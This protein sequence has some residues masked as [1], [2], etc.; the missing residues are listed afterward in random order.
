MS[1]GSRVIAQRSLFAYLLAVIF[2]NSVVKC[3]ITSKMKRDSDIWQMARQR[4]RRGESLMLLVVAE[5]TGSSPGRAGYKMAVTAGGELAGS[6]GGGMMEVNL[7]EQSRSILSEPGAV[8]RGFLPGTIIQQIHQK[9]SPHSSGMICSGR[10]TVIFRMLTPE[11]LPLIN[12]ILAAAENSDRPRLTVSRSAIELRHGAE[13][14]TPISFELLR[15]DDFRYSE[16]LDASGSLFIIGGGHCALALSEV[17]SRLDFRISI[18]D[19]RH[20]LNTIEKNR[21]ADVVKI[22]ET[23]DKI[24]DLIPSGDDVFVVAMTVGYLSDQ[25]VIRQLFNRDFKY[26]GVLGSR[27]KVATMFRELEAEGFD[28]ERLSRISSPIG[29]PINSRTPEEIAVSIAAEI[30]A[31]KNGAANSRGQ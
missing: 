18:L 4:L 23:Y 1:K 3:S 12:D 22:V 14:E 6:I 13:G 7:V 15:N 24:G 17:M 10:Q 30:I 31:V 29:I 16:T 19:D 20:N 5:S 9:N 25:A 2:V 11:D 21:F 26:F 27:A 8:A 28:K